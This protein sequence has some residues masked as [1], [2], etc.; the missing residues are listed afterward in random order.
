MSPPS[1]KDSGRAPRDP[2]PMSEEED[3][4]NSSPQPRQQGLNRPHNRNQPTASSS[5]TTIP[6]RSGGSRP[7]RAP[8]AVHDTVGCLAHPEGC[9]ICDQYLDHLQDAWDNN[10]QRVEKWWESYHEDRIKEAYERGLRH[11]SSDGAKYRERLHESQE[12]NATLQRRISQLECK[13][14]SSSNA[15][16]ASQS[17]VSE[18]VSS[19]PDGSSKKRRRDPAD[20]SS[21]QPRS[22]SH[23]VRGFDLYAPPRGGRPPPMIAPGQLPYGRGNPYTN[24]YGLGQRPRIDLSHNPWTTNPLTMSEIDRARSPN[25]QRDSTMWRSYAHFANNTPP[26]QRTPEQRAF[27]SVQG[28]QRFHPDQFVPYTDP[29]PDAELER[30]YGDPATVQSKPGSPSSPKKS[31]PKPTTPNL[32]QLATQPL[33]SGEFVSVG[34][35]ALNASTA[36]QWTT[37]LA[38]SQ[39]DPSSNSI[40]PGI[41]LENGI[42]NS[43]DIYIFEW[44]RA[45]GPNDPEQWA[46]YVADIQYIFG[47]PS[48]YYNLMVRTRMTTVSSVLR[49]APLPR[50]SNTESYSDIP[51]ATRRDFIATHFAALGLSYQFVASDVEPFF[52]R[53]AQ[54]RRPDNQ[55]EDMTS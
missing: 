9:A 46:T 50:H 45:V 53:D 52:V 10:F 8:I 4:D 11:G 54:A 7:I 38:V 20:P 35:L 25:F 47:H 1:K 36:P 15:D 43:H 2:S 39:F 42:H 30:E 17:N 3:E 6:P 48:R 24:P 5:R 34:R 18:S 16:S 33:L 26:A 40:P 55:D 49:Y 29:S 31:K 21:G 19:E 12:E 37:S 41:R 23:N 44:F 28:G 13:T 27:L 32:A 14:A 51:A 22:M